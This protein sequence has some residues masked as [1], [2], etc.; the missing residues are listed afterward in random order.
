MC[1]NAQ[2]TYS[3]ET[4]FRFDI[5]RKMTHQSQANVAEIIADF[6]G[7]YAKVARKLK[8]SPSMVSRVGGGHRISPEI[9][10]ALREELK[11][12]RERLDKHL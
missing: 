10:A 3:D 7:L 6:R 2:R 12:L 5:L 9:E 11:M 4:N 1:S 8:I